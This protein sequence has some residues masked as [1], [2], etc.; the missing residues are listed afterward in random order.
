M[1]PEDLHYEAG[2]VT[3]LTGLTGRQLRYWD[4]SGLFPAS[5]RTGDGER[6]QGT[7]RL[8]SFRDLV[9]LRAIVKIRAMNISTQAIR[10]A[11]DYLRRAFPDLG[12]DF[13]GVTFVVWGTDLLALP[14][15]ESLPIS[16]V[17]AQ[18]QRVMAIPIDS[19]SAEV[20]QEVRE[21]QWVV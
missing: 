7:R 17:K 16:I 12:G 13:A 4:S 10:R 18:G 19:I 9:L 11:F 20:A 21:L 2:D 15:G 14:P 5:G 6:R 8:W 1:R 3:R